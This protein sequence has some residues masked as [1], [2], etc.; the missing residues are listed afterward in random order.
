MSNSNETQP[1]QEKQQ[2]ITKELTETLSV[3]DTT[4]TPLSSSEQEQHPEQELEEQRLGASQQSA[5]GQ[6]LSLDEIQQRGLCNWCRNPLVMSTNFSES[7]F[8]DIGRKWHPDDTDNAQ[9]VYCE[10]CLNSQFRT[11]NPKAV[12]DR[13]NLSTTNIDELPDLNQGT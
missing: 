8:V 1:G 7:N 2:E 5:S 12:I 4:T 11:D 10:D 9:A 13:T 6:P 3:S